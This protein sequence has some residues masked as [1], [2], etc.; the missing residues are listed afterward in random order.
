MV[1]PWKVGLGKDSRLERCVN[2]C[3]TSLFSAHLSLDGASQR[4]GRHL[5]HRASAV[6][7]FVV[8][9]ASRRLPNGMNQARFACLAEADANRPVEA[10]LFH[11]SFETWVVR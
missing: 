11:F 2:E 7:P 5:P 3:L 6:R 9:K 1:S 4:A 8:H 10:D